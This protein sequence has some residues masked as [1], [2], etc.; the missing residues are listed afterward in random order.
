MDGTLDGRIGPM[1]EDGGVSEERLLAD[2][3][4]GDEAAF[5]LLV[6][7]HRGDLYAHCYRML[8]SVQ[9]AEDALQES[10]LGAWRGL[11]GFEGRS[12]LRTWLYRVATHACLRLSSRRPRRM[13][14]SDHGP[15][16]SDVHDLGDP[17]PGPVWLDPLPDDLP[18][19][20]EPDPAAAY[21][22]RESVELA[23]VAA[24]QQLPGTQR[25]VLILREVLGFTAA[26]VAGILDTTPASVNSA[27]Q[28][29]RA[30]LQ[31]R[32]SQQ[33][34]LAAL[35]A[36]GRRALVDAFVTAWERADVPALL[37]L[38]TEDARFTMPPLPAWFDGREDVGRFLAERVFATQW[39][40]VP[41][42]ANGQPGFACHQYDGER[43]SLG[44]VNVLSLRDG[45]IS[46]IAAFIDPQVTRYFSVPGKLSR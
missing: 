2:A 30:A 5:A 21:L 32:R 17:V 44:A 12:S 1:V 36:G 11:A 20:E 4:K 31:Q 45:R 26:E 25:A 7:R 16:R 24:L 18:A 35:G 37:D 22:R 9:D 33:A 34:E 43:F 14:S 6:K 19:E 8:G 10:L 28:R 15:A 29:A 38:L 46:W 41:I 13:L 42:A 39:R 27:M 40:L 23:F 3:Q